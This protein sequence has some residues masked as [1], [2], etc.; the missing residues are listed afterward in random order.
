MQD[1]A[2]IATSN[3]EI[4]ASSPTAKITTPEASKNVEEFQEQST[5]DC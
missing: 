2:V 3:V 1:Y 4:E 5:T